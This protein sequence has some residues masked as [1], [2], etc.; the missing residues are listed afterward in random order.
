MAEGLSGLDLL[1]NIRQN[2]NFGQF[3]ADVES[4]ISRVKAAGGKINDAVGN[5]VDPRQVATETGRALDL[6]NQKIAEN[7]R[8]IK[9]TPGDLKLAGNLDGEIRKLETYKRQLTE[10]TR[11]ART[12]D[13]G[14][15]ISPKSAYGD[16]L[17]AEAR[18]RR[19]ADEAEHRAALQRG[20]RRTE[21]AKRAEAAAKRTG[22]V[23]ED[24]AKKAGRAQEDA[25]KKAGAAERAEAEKTK[26]AKEKTA[27]GGG[28]SKPPPPPS[29]GTAAPPPEGHR[30]TAANI[31]ASNEVWD[32]ARNAPSA[33]QP[34]AVDYGEARAAIEKMIRSTL[35][36]T[37]LLE[38]MSRNYMGVI[39][40]ITHEKAIRRE[41]AVSMERTAGANKRLQDAVANEQVAIA[42]TRIEQAKRFDVGQPGA[43]GVRAF[44]RTSAL[45][46]ANVAE[47]NNSLSRRN[48]E[49]GKT[50]SG[51]GVGLAGFNKYYEGVL[52]RQISI[53]ETQLNLDLGAAEEMAKQKL[54]L[55]QLNREVAQRVRAGT[56]VKAVAKDQSDQASL[57]R[58]ISI[59]RTKL[60]LNNGVAAEIARE[61]V[62]RAELNREIARETRSQT[63]KAA[64]AAESVAKARDA[65]VQSA[66][67]RAAETP[68][69]RQGIAQDKVAQAARDR[70]IARRMRASTDTAAV[71]AD[72]ADKA[73]ASV[74]QRRA[75]LQAVTPAD[76]AGLA[77]LAVEQRLGS[78]Q[79]KLA[80]IAEFRSAA[81]IRTLKVE[82]ELAGETARLKAEQAK[83]AATDQTLIRATAEEA[84]AREAQAA[85]VALARAGV[86]VGDLAGVELLAQAA[87][88]KRTQSELQKAEIARRTGQQDID[89]A[90]ARKLEEA[91]LRAAINARE[92]SLIRE[93]VASGEV[94]KGTAF[95]RIQFGLS[96]NSNKLPEEYLKGGQFLGDKLQ[97]TAGYA[98]TGAVLGGSIA[99]I[100][101]MVRDASKLEV[102]F[103]RLRGQMEGLDQGGAFPA[104]RDQ[105]REVA[106]ETGQAS[107]DVA[108]FY[109]RMLGLS[110]DPAEALR[111]TASAMKLMTVTGLDAGTAMQ[112]LVPIQKAFGVSVE[113]IGD[114]VVE[115]GEK[116]GVSEDD[117]TQFLGKTAAAAKGAGLSFTELT[118]LGGNLANSLGKPI[119]SASESINKSFT[120][121]EN[122]KEKILQILAS[123]PATATAI[124]P[125]VDAFAG[126][127]T[128]D[129]LFS[130]LKV[131]QNLTAAQKNQLLTNVVSRRE[132]EEFNAIIQN[133]AGILNDVAT[134][135]AGTGTATGKLQQRFGS[136]QQTVQVTGK[137][138]SAAFE[139]LG[140]TLFRSGLS[141]FLVDLGNSLKLVVGA[142]GLLLAVFAKIN[143]VVKI[144]GTDEGILAVFAKIAL[145]SLALNKGFKILAATRSIGSKIT[146]KETESEQRS[147]ASKSESAAATERSAAAERDLAAS[148]TATTGG[149]VGGSP[150]VVSGGGTATAVKEATAA[151]KATAAAAAAPL[152]LPRGPNVIPLGAVGATE[153]AAAGRLAAREAELTSARLIEE[154][155]IAETE[156]LLRAEA[157]ARANANRALIDQI[158]RQNLERS[159]RK[160]LLPYGPTPTANPTEAL[161][162][163]GGQYAAQRALGQRQ[164]EL[165]E[166]L[167]GQQP[168]ALGPGSQYT[169]QQI[170]N[171]RLSAFE[172]NTGRY[173]SLESGQFVK[174]EVAREAGVPIPPVIPPIALGAGPQRITPLRYGDVRDATALR[175]AEGR[176]A[177]QSA[178]S[179]IRSK[180]RSEPLQLGPGS[181]NATGP[182]GKLPP[183][184]LGEDALRVTPGTEVAIRQSMANE[185]RVAAASGL[186]SEASAGTKLAGLGGIAG[187]LRGAPAAA[188]DSAR[189]LGQS[190]RSWLTDPSA[191][192]QR[193]YDK[194]AGEFAQNAPRVGFGTRALAGGE[195]RF[196]RSAKADAA[197]KSTGATSALTPGMMAIIALAGAAAVKTAYDDQK[198]KVEDAARGLAAQIRDADQ[199]NLDKLK[200]Y[201]S[202][203]WEFLASEV[204]GTPTVEVL[205]DAEQS[206]RDST[207]GRVFLG[208]EH[209]VAKK[210]VLQ[211]LDP[212]KAQNAATYQDLYK[213]TAASLSGAQLGSLGQTLGRTDDTRAFFEGI[214]IKFNE[215]QTAS[216]EE[217][218][219]RETTPEE[220]KSYEAQVTKENAPQILSALASRKRYVGD[221]KA[222]LEAEK[223]FDDIYTQVLGFTQGANA[224]P[225]LA[226]LSAKLAAQGDSVAAAQAAGGVTPY[227]NAVDNING[228][229][230]T[231]LDELKKQLE[232]GAITQVEF[233]QRQ[234]QSLSIL[235]L[236]AKKFYGTDGEKARNALLD[237]NKYT[238]DMLYKS[239]LQLAEL[240]QKFRGVNSVRPKTD[241]LNSHLKA[242]RGTDFITQV[243]ELPK[244]MDEVLAAREEQA[245]QIANPFEQAAFLNKPIEL[246]TAQKAVYMEDQINKNQG[247]T[248]ELKSTA[249]T[250]GMDPETF[251]KAVFD[252]MDATGKSPEEAL[253]DVAQQQ[254]DK[255]F[256]MADQY[257]KVFGEGSAEAYLARQTA[258]G[259]LDKK[260]AIED[261]EH[262][263]LAGVDTGTS[264]PDYATSRGRELEAKEKDRESKAKVYNAQYS[265]NPLLKAAQA[266]RDADA[267]Y[268][269]ML[270]KRSIG[271]ATDQ[272]VAE[273]RAQQLEAHSTEQDANHA[274]DKLRSNRRV[275]EANG[276]PIAETAANLQNLY[277]ELAYLKSLGADADPSDI[278][279]V[280]QEIIKSGQQQQK[281]QLDL[282]RSGMSITD[283]LIERNPL[284]AAQAALRRAEFEEKNAIGVAA[285][286]EA[287][288]QR[289]KAQH[290]L[291][292][293]LSRGAEARASLAIAVAN[294]NDDPVEAARLAAT[295]AKRKLDEA[296]AR[297]VV[298]DEALAPLR[299]ASISANR[300]LVRTQVQDQ[301]DTID[302]M[303]QM[304]QISTTQALA[305]LKAVLATVQVGSK[306]YE[307]LSLKIRSLTQSAQQDLQ[308]NLPTT[309]GLPTL[310]ES[311]RTRQ[312]LQA[313]VGYQDNRNVAVAISVN[314]AQD[315]AA[316]A[317]QVASALNS[318]LRGGATYTAAVPVGA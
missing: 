55:A 31:K 285:K 258:Q 20:A 228:Q 14:K 93:A 291:E 37:A 134:A 179:G 128:G 4:A 78:A 265:R 255:W 216:A 223:G 73:R 222:K 94:K 312:N 299:A 122:N 201:R 210:A 30:S 230:F 112:S 315:P 56:D 220:R 229:Q 90:A 302:Y 175:E 33:G 65:R 279:N 225:Q 89:A 118:A 69:D 193:R 256:A 205:H 81:G 3:A 138:I 234:Q 101:E 242:L 49:I 135:Q 8:I 82:Q 54:L 126:G 211:E 177:L 206:F 13:G 227:L 41:L 202:D 115:M 11:A 136:L 1:V 232:A 155:R 84:N 261:T 183:L 276:D 189:I 297:G 306:E 314:G 109:A 213:Q 301:V 79:Q 283:A 22:A 207:P 83:L 24:A 103:V 160:D 124:G 286:Q 219:V 236:E 91:K 212:T 176:A 139:S 287:E 88:V 71:A 123:N 303:Q 162:L 277:E 197:L 40:T 251:K 200:N 51:P 257:D 246:P 5:R 208:A 132:A 264:T 104:I 295:E 74:A 137:T 58:Q 77:T 178:Q 119:D 52:R 161:A 262:P 111:D 252:V 298:D 142:A 140:D 156:R 181:L 186:A 169:R 59:E 263:E 282:I 158:N 218:S 284:Q 148:R 12:P 116:F 270:E 10:V 226:G 100:S 7:R 313:G 16:Q 106:A 150:Y 70:D 311:R 6:M 125:M 154:A 98:V 289:I 146:D 317:A 191:G 182:G 318:S 15:P 238:N 294:A 243:N 44:E 50:L 168:L 133:S 267:A 280:E 171:A 87:V 266:S 300:E 35:E 259:Y 151:E 188:A 61:K 76:R 67:N 278:E 29:A 164:R 274:V 17:Q 185:Y 247:A 152:A 110:H 131:V 21:E 97:R 92:K 62:I 165:Y 163:G 217:Q 166:R 19:Q 75:D 25:A 130:M 239:R 308:F 290:G 309:L 194:F 254:A 296:I 248:E 271:K 250:L 43:A 187:F 224:A 26:K 214:G 66:F 39:D 68:A 310:Y 253:A 235:E 184:N 221:D 269:D 245:S 292:D 159:V 96:P 268:L 42:R 288:A 304:G 233:Q 9:Q 190:G 95:Q 121:L 307:Q 72:N 108:E 48:I 316:V 195:T 147:S 143:E 198:S 157:L 85:R 293:A 273:K 127:R 149:T 204:F 105:I 114:S 86:N 260:K 241:A 63:N 275:L 196:T 173:R 60:D 192:Y 203:T 144:P 46:E 237:A 180:L 57:N 117:L 231:S 129:A 172:Q 174:G 244:V 170:G 47:K 32:D 80:E 27:A 2:N 28:A 64:V 281:N 240:G 209:Y 167:L 305:S 199:T 102:T 272:D 215:K 38:T 153:E 23:Q 18:A 249:Y 113:E 120:L 141:E 107:N 145:T 99:A 53:R 34:T 45:A 36:N